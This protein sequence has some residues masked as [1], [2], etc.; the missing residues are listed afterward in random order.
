MI[1][2]A[3]LAAGVL[4]AVVGGDLFV[5]G[6]V[7]LAAWWRVPAGLIGA[8]IAAFAT[9]SPE[10]TVAITSALRGRP[11]IALGDA[12]GSNVVNLGVV[13]GL[14][15]IF[16]A[17]KV[18][19]GALAR[20]IPMALAAPAVLGVFCLDGTLGRLEATVMLLVFVGWLTQSV[21]AA[22]RVR[23]SV[24]MDLQER[25]HRA[26]V[27]SVVGGLALLVLSGRL[28]VTG[29]IGVSEALGWDGFVVGA[30][31]VAIGTSAPEIATMLAARAHGHDDIGVGTVLGSNIFNTLLIVGV[32]ALISPVEIARTEILVGTGASML[33]ILLALPNR[34]GHLRRW[35]SAPLLLT[36]VALVSVMIGTSQA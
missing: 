6:V 25:T 3:V 26:T 24:V 9:S 20:D 15:L 34:S 14:A 2:S 23:D 10:L 32:A 7:S 30:L 35:R 27:L 11:E 12:L 1:T 17:V 28:I 16:G 29:A 5:R 31:F 13:L 22:R 19:G 4:C 33:V 21:L 36:Y 8:T 18:E